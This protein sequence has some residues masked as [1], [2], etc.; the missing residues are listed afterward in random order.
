[1]LEK[2]EKDNAKIIKLK[3]KEFMKKIIISLLGGIAVV[4]G[5]IL[6]INVLFNNTDGN[7]TLQVETTIDYAEEKDAVPTVIET[8]DGKIEVTDEPATVNFVDS[9]KIDECPEESEECARGAGNLPYLDITSPTT[10]Y[11][12]FIGQCIDFDGAFGSQC[13]D[14]MAYFHYMYTGRWLSACGTGAA[15]GI[16]ECRDVNNQG[17]EY[18]LITDTHSLRAGDWVIFHNGIYGHVG[19][20]LGGY[21][22]N[23]I[24]LLGT[25]QGGAACVGGGAVANVINMSL[26][27]FSGAFRP[28]IW[29]QPE[30]KP[31][32]QPTGNYV[33]QKGD[34]FS[35]VLMKLGLSD[36]SNLWGPNGDVNFYNKQLF[37][38]GILNYYNGKYWNNIPIGT[39]IVLEAR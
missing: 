25:N 4:I 15:Y 27:S 19:M 22:N 37:D 38:K 18:E 8:E 3:R 31:T 1:M 29:I 10:V 26:T 14:E 23:Y 39:E 11:N 9:G 33:Y 5:S 6:G 35:A 20:A 28:K 21:N 32:P 2:K 17:G 34:Y 16:W 13:F 7:I 12:S 36:G 30:P 24:A